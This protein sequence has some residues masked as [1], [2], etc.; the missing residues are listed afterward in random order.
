MNSLMFQ[1]SAILANGG[2]KM[3]YCACNI[4]GKTDRG[5]PTVS[6]YQCIRCKMVAICSGLFCEEKIYGTVSGHPSTN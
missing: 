6:K 5:H 2:Y 4:A 3:Y 1:V